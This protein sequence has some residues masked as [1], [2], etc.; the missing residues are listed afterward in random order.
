MST[1]EMAPS[2]GIGRND[3][4]RDLVDLQG[5][6]NGR[7]YKRV[8][9]VEPGACKPPAFYLLPQRDAVFMAKGQL[10]DEDKKSLVDQLAPL[11]A[12]YAS[13]LLG[14]HTVIS[15]QGWRDFDVYWQKKE[16]A[17]LVGLA[18]VPPQR[19]YRQRHRQPSAA[20]LFDDIIAGNM[21]GTPT[22]LHNDR[23]TQAKHR[24]LMQA[25]DLEHNARYA[26]ESRP[27]EFTILFGDEQWCIG[28]TPSKEM[29][30]VDPDAEVFFPRSLRSQ[31]V[32]DP[33][34]REANTQVHDITLVRVL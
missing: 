28:I 15:C 5:S 7:P 16:F 9:T 18:Y 3:A 25:L 13:R 21:E 33:S 27:G 17:H 6:P 32:S 29:M 20:V 1:R 10:T 8:P 31:N 22:Q 14:K 26:V 19:Y 11:A 4:H 23:I 12:L 30:P 24:A 2:L 34:L